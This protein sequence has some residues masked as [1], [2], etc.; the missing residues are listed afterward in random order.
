[1]NADTT[2]LQTHI[3]LEAIHAHNALDPVPKEWRKILYLERNKLEFATHNCA[4]YHICQH[5]YIFIDTPNCTIGIG[6][7]GIGVKTVASGIESMKIKIRDNEG[8][9]HEKSSGT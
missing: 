6:I 5:L 9:D 2:I 8:A 7:I 1:M 3:T 4:T